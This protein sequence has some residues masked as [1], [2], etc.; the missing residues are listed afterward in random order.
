[1]SELYIYHFYLK[2][3][4][5]YFH[6]AFLN[7]V[8][9]FYYF[10]LKEFYRL[11]IYQNQYLNKLSFHIYQKVLK[12][13]NH[14]HPCNNHY[15][16]YNHKYLLLPYLQ[17]HI[18]FHLKFHLIYLLFSYILPSFMQLGLFQSSICFSIYMI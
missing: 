4:S 1:M 15:I 3:Y 14:P 5:F 11:I 17:Y 8:M 9:L 13:L 6:L 12:L 2:S 18:I 7:K 16:H 10:L